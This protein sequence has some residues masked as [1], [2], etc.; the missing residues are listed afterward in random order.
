MAPERS[1]Q[2]D[3]GVALT[4]AAFSRPDILPLYG[5]SELEI[6]IPGRA[7]D[8]FRSAPDGFTICP[9]GQKG[10]SPLILT[11]KLAAAGQAPAAGKVAVLISPTWFLCRGE[12]LSSYAGNFSA[13][14]GMELMFKAPLSPGLRR[15]IARRMLDFPTTLAGNP[16]LEQAIRSVAQNDTPAGRSA[17]ALILPRGLMETKVM[18]MQDH[19]E[20][21]RDVLT[22]SSGPTSPGSTAQID[23][24][25]LI[26]RANATSPVAQLPDIPS[27]QPQTLASIW[28][29]VGQMP[30]CTEW[31][32]LDL[33]L[34]TMQELHIQALLLD[35]PW[36][37][38]Y[39]DS[40][41]VGAGIRDTYYAR[42]QSLADKYH[43]PLATF[44]DHE[45][46][47]NFLLDSRSHISAKGWM[48][49][50]RDIDAFWRGRPLPYG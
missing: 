32:D 5:S 14:Q 8:F 7:S 40:K 47:P 6:D 1:L 44:Q 18:E 43:T 15:D 10:A 2:R 3:L 29:G 26:A 28:Q 24:D 23:W 12:S 35:I 19:Y 11:E 42:L 22:S 36:Y 25:H 45:Y 16:L 48:L 30:N 9:I 13:L 20:A 50:N 31:Q 37:A 41:G 21:M 34:R 27:Q 4:R 33:L 49:F 39:Y 38:S 17:Y 46:D